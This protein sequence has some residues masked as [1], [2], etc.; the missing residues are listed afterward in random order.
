MISKPAGSVQKVEIS[1]TDDQLVCGRTDSNFSV[2]PKARNRLCGIT[3]KDWKI[4]LIG[5]VYRLLWSTQSGEHLFKPVRMRNQS[6]FI[7][8]GGKGIRKILGMAWF[9]QEGLPLVIYHSTRCTKMNKNPTQK[10]LTYPITRRTK[11]NGDIGE[12]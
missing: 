3:E 12:K 11:C 5:S 10:T 7:D 8:G 2:K 4:T 9:S 6:L 1:A